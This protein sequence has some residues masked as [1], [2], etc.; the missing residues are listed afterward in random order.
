MLALGADG[1]GGVGFPGNCGDRGEV[2]PGI[3]RERPREL[4]VRAAVQFA[5]RSEAE[6]ADPLGGELAAG[7]LHRGLDPPDDPL[8][9][10]RRD[11]PL[12]GGVQ[13]CGPELGPVESLARAAPLHYIEGVGLAALEGGEALTA[14]DALSA[15]A[16]HGAALG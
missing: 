2:G 9:L 1:T 7:M 13:K 6:L 8:D 3:V 16:R 10:V 12:V 4:E 5:E 11:P 15:A 14:F